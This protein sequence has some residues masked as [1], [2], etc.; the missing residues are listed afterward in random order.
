MPA[1]FRELEVFNFG[2]VCLCLLARVVRLLEDTRFRLSSIN[3]SSEQPCTKCI[4]R[5]VKLYCLVGEGVG[6]HCT[7]VDYYFGCLV[8]SS[9]KVKEDP[10][11]NDISLYTLSARQEVWIEYGGYDE[12]EKRTTHGNAV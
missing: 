3:S 7:R 8:P 1:L 11:S 4:Y 12:Q 9:T 10:G 6:C 2:F 5:L